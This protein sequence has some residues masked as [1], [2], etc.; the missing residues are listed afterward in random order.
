[1]AGASRVL[2]P[3]PSS[4][5]LSTRWEQSVAEL[6]LG[7]ERREVGVRASSCSPPCTQVTADSAHY[8]PVD[9]RTCSLRWG[10]EM[11]SPGSSSGGLSPHPP[12]IGPRTGAL[13]SWLTWGPGLGRG[14]G[15]ASLGFCPD[16]CFIPAAGQRGSCPALS[17]LLQGRRTPVLLLT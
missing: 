8:W 13:T 9:R 2:P 7:R 1:M 15:S 6:K 17:Q 14:E 5:L 10:R 12:G 4:H 11:R 3:P 16:F